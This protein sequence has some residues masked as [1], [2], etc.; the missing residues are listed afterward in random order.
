MSPFAAYRTERLFA[1]ILIGFAVNNVLPLRLGELV[2]T[3]LL[4]QSHGVP[5]ASTLATIADR[6]AAGRL[7]AL[8]NPD[9]VLCWPVGEGMAAGRFRHGG[10]DHGRGGSPACWSCWS[11]RAALVEQLFAVR[12]SDRRPDPSEARQAG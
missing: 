3:F 2:R 6:A 9:V 1:I 5:I 11:C 12:H 8:R 10:D 7:R 4:R